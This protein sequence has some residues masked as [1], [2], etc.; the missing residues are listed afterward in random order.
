M[1]NKLSAIVSCTVHSDVHTCTWTRYTQQ[2]DGTGSF[3]GTRANV[4]LA[5]AYR[6]EAAQLYSCLRAPVGFLPI[7]CSLTVVTTY[8]L[9]FVKTL[10]ETTSITFMFVSQTFLPLKNYYGLS[11][12][13]IEAIK[14]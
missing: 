3:Y 14:L 1:T 7:L 11:F 5:R 6:P 12:I 4:C 9:V 10:D 8:S 2:K 13:L